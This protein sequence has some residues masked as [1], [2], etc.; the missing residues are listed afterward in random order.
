MQEQIK[1]GRTLS[2]LLL[3]A[4]GLIFLINVFYPLY[5]S[6]PDQSNRIMVLLMMLTVV[7]LA[8]KGVPGM[9]IVIGGVLLVLALFDGLVLITALEAGRVGLSIG[10]GSLILLF[11]SIGWLLLTSNSVKQFE[12]ARKQK[13]A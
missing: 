1:R 4:V 13:A 9:R 2:L 12:S 3:G 5:L 10:I 11:L 8:Y 6:G 7:A